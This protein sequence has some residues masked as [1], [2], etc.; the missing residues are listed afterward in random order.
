M[1]RAQLAEMQER[2]NLLLAKKETIVDQ[3]SISRAAPED[4]DDFD[5]DD[6]DLHSPVPPSNMSQ[7]ADEVKQ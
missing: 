6:K 2:I 1:L 5:E 7:Y 4:E 3:S